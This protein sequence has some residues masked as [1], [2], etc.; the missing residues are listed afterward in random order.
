MHERRAIPWEKKDCEVLV[1]KRPVLIYSLT[2]QALHIGGF[3]RF[4][5]SPA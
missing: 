1:D 3:L 5:I 2:Y 4:H